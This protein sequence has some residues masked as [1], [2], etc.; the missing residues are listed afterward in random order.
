M[1]LLYYLTISSGIAIFALWLNVNVYCSLTS[2]NGA[3]V[4]RGMFP[5]EIKILEGRGIRRRETK[6]R[7]PEQCNRCAFD[8]FHRSTGI[9]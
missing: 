6:I 1:I 5:T 3:R 7:R 4:K 2:G 9:P 8:L